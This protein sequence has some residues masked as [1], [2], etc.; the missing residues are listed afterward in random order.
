MITDIW[1]EAR[2]NNDR[3]LIS[4]WMLRLEKV[5]TG[6]TSW[7]VEGTA[8]DSHTHTIG[9]SECDKYRCTYCNVLSKQIFK[10]GWTCLNQECKV[11]FH[12][13]KQFDDSTIGH[14][15]LDDDLI[16]YH[17]KFLQERSDPAKR[18]R[19][20]LMPLAPPVLND[21]DEVTRGQGIICPKCHCCTRRIHWDRWECEEPSCDFVLKKSPRV[22]GLEEINQENEDYKEA[23]YK[24]NGKRRQGGFYW[25]ENVIL[26]HLA[27]KMAGYSVSVYVLPDEHG[28]IIGTVMIYRAT[29]QIRA[30]PNGPNDMLLTMQEQDLNLKRG[31]ARHPGSAF[32]NS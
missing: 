2:L 18:I 12:F 25:D 30:L 16:Q 4:Y 21:S 13:Q 28:K 7:W 10:N 8:D 19:K 29:D 3:V 1:S 5:P 14:V 24:K 31:A 9:Q 20:P 27:T 26:Q 15:V 23:E 6:Q 22:Y 32:Q 11:F 17:D